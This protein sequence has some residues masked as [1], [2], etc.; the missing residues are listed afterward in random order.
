[1]T[2]GGAPPQGA[3]IDI[4]PDR[5]EQQERQVGRHHHR[6]EGDARQGGVEQGRP[7]ADAAVEQ[8]MADAIDGERR[9]EMQDWRAN[10]HAGAAVA[11][12]RR[13]GGDQPGDHRRLGVV[14]EGEIL[15][16]HP[17]LGF[18]RMQIEGIDR[19]IDHAQ[20]RQRREQEKRAR[21]AV[22][23]AIGEREG[24]GL[25]GR[26]RHKNSPRENAGTLTDGPAP[27]QENAPTESAW[28]KGGLASAPLRSSGKFAIS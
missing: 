18:V 13:G 11:A 2:D 7:E 20:Q 24:R 8:A 21:Q 4:E 16:P 27:R 28:K 10:A 19:E 1:M 23:A 26:T 9:E 14:A 22:D 12:N 17:I 15:G 6:G 3:H 5:P 25:G